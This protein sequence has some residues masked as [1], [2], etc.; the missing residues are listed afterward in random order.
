MKGSTFKRCGC[1]DGAGKPLGGSCPRLRSK[2]HGTWYY[3]AELPMGPKGERRIKRRGGFVTRQD[4]DVALTDLLDRV[5]KRTH[6]DAGRQPVG[7]YFEQWL[8]G[9]AQI[10][11]T[12]ARSYAEHVTLY[13]TPV[14]GHLRL[15]DLSVT[16]IEEL[17]EAMRQLGRTKAGASSSP[18]LAQ[19]LAA[20]SSPELARPLSAARIRRVHATL[21]SALNS[22]VKR[23]LIPFNPAL[24]VELAQAGRPKAL[25]WT[26]ERT[27]AW[28]AWEAKTSAAATAVQTAAHRFKIAER[29]ARQHPADGHAAASCAKLGGALVAAKA[30]LAQITTTYQPPKVAV[31]TPEQTGRFLDSAV[32]DRLYAMYHL[33][34][35]RGLRRGEAVGA[36]W[37]NANLERA[38]LTIC[39]QILQLG[40]DTVGATPKS[41]SEGTI[42]LDKQTVAVLRAHR[43]QQD[44]DRQAWGPAWVQ[45]GLMFT[46]ENG[47][48]LHPEYVS[49]H[50]SWLAASAGLPPIRLHDLR[51]GAATLALASGA[52]LKVVSEMLRHSSITIT[53]DTYTSVL[54]EVSRRAAEAAVALVP[55]ATSPASTHPPEVPVMEVP[56]P[57]RSHMAPKATPALP[58][59]ERKARSDGVRRQGLEPRTRGLR[60]RCSAN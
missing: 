37:T 40:Y 20:R 33:I 52:D 44:A 58:S 47:A 12:T 51:H 18:E 27:D 50:F 31:W 24:Y 30:G 36:S 15:A 32:S 21:R 53:A 28:R 4:A 2:N 56:V 39:W 13:L 17:Y 23:R 34:A 5:N 54:P 11:S 8:A 7:G 55:R 48:A 9:K 45:T 3:K 1:R 60:V 49:R 41:G 38:E 43:A 19:L 14:L 59:E 10:R 16:D 22:A 57:H 26:G 35:F 42:A 6:I 25:L 46:K 29:R